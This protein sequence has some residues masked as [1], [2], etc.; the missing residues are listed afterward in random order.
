MVCHGANGEERVGST[1]AKPWSSVRPDLSLKNAIVKGVPG[2]P[3][4]AWSQEY[5]GPLS[6]SEVNDI[7][8]YILSWEIP[9]QNGD[10]PESR[11]ISSS[12]F[13]GWGGVFVFWLI[14]L[15]LIGIILFL[16]RRNSNQDA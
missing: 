12:W 11:E 8:A 14:F 6:E 3:M 13:T 15:F 9:T 10:Q 1:L 16:Q 7:V 5:G 2:S 4:P